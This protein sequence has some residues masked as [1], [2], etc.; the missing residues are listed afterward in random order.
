MIG[1]DVPDNFTKMGHTPIK[2][3]PQQHQDHQAALQAQLDEQ[4]HNIL[5]DYYN[6]LTT[7]QQKLLDSKA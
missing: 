3:S 6:T 4:Q 5:T 2:H 1:R 7:Q